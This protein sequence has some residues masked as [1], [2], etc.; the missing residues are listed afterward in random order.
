MKR[1]KGKHRS[2]AH[3]LPR[4]NYSGKAI[5]FLTL[6]ANDRVC[7]LGKIDENRKIQKHVL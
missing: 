5:Y 2:E 7:H 6:V 1:L 3:R 4:W